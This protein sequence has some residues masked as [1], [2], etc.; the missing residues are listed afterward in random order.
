MFKKIFFIPFVLFLISFKS[1][2]QKNIYIFATINDDII[3]NFDIK[4]ETEYLKILNPDLTKLS[5]KKVFQL[6]KD[7]LIKEIIKKNEI[8][9]FY[10]FDEKNTF[11]QDYLKDLYTRLN[12]E[13]E[14]E[15]KNYLENSSN[16]SIDEVKQKL[17]IELMWN[18]LIYS[19]YYNQ[20]NINKDEMIKKI[21]DLSNQEINEYFLSEIVFR[22]DKNQSLENQIDLIF[23]SINDVGF[24]NTANIYSLSESSK[25]GGKIGW[26][27]QNNLSEIIFNKLENLNEGEISEIIQSGNN[28]IIL[29][30]EKIRKKNLSINKN[31]E[32]NKMIQ[33]ETNKQLNQFSK[34]Y[35]D[36]SMINYS[37]DEK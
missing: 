25:L 31:D 10:D 4:K 6:S 21:D 36:K 34:I 18:E 7:S 1:Y 24:E 23:A 11:V 2:A 26:V 27:N 9:K 37:I 33:F 8:K 12:F 13:N 14:D 15:F 5:K 35:F 16:Y 30:I 19:R 28:Y 22:K 29:K 3:T 17:K 32:L 20:V